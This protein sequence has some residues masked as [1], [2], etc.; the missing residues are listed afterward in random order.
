MVFLVSSTGLLGCDDAGGGEYELTQYRPNES[1]PWR[2]FD[3]FRNLCTPSLCP[4]G[5]PDCSGTVDRFG[6]DV[7]DLSHD[8]D[9]F[10]FFQGDCSTCA[11]GEEHLPPN[12]VYRSGG[13]YAYYEG[14]GSLA[15]PGME[16]PLDWGSF[17]AR[18]GHVRRYER[19]ACSD[20]VDL[21]DYGV[22]GQVGD[23]ICEKLVAMRHEVLVKYEVFD[24]CTVDSMDESVYLASMDCGVETAANYDFI[25]TY[26][27]VTPH[28]VWWRG[29]EGDFSIEI[30]LWWRIVAG[31]RNDYLLCSEGTCEQF[32][33]CDPAD[34]D[35]CAGIPGATCTAAGLCVNEHFIDVVDEGF[36]FAIDD[37][38][39]N[40]ICRIIRR[41][42]ERE[43]RDYAANPRGPVFS[44][45]LDR[46]EQAL[47]QDD[48]RACEDDGDCELMPGTPVEYS[49]GEFAARCML[50]ED[51]DQ[52]T[53]HARPYH[54][55]RVNL[56]PRE[57]ELV[58][59]RDDLDAPYYPLRREA[60]C[61]GSP[62][63]AR[64]LEGDRWFQGIWL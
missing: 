37:H 47:W 51:A 43:L 10:V 6:L 20:A 61:D 38:C 36:D 21:I 50:G 16:A 53:C 27:R 5:M 23:A 26:N 18:V 63:M 32:V 2:T 34:P 17:Q 7:T 55:Y 60:Y 39:R 48:G 44:L 24:S 29:A 58:L 12:L 35:A 4:D 49:I 31:R 25:V 40:A 13:R 54:V 3:D 57:L 8:R 45:L 15:D 52:R 9:R 56:Y 42:A 14:A 19:G 28:I 30:W 62:D 1:E 33:Y 46:I 11:L 41:R 64:R 22:A 59:A